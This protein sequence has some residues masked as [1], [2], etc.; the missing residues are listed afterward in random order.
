M[1]IKAI[2]TVYSGYRFR[3]RLEARW[4]VFFN[5]LSVRFEY[6]KEGF[7]LGGVRYLPDFWLPQQKI[8]VEIKGESPAPEET[9][10][11]QRLAT[12]TGRMAF[13]FAGDIVVPQDTSTGGHQVN[14]GVPF[15]PG[16]DANDTR[17]FY[18]DFATWYDCPHCGQ[19]GLMA[20]LET[21]RGRQYSTACDCI[22]Q[23]W[24]A[25][26]ALSRLMPP[27]VQQCGSI[28]IGGMIPTWITD[29]RWFA[30]K[31]MQGSPRLVAAYT[32]ARQARFEHGESGAPR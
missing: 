16:G 8:W 25:V 18:S 3:S 13:I 7:D 4:A 9:D 23:W 27:A 5:H 24:E 2:E 6:E 1:F 29:V 32:A 17:S 12:A 31:M 14:T 11:A 20:Q 22:V 15:Y 19:L 30:E 28:A 10:K 21:R 26:K